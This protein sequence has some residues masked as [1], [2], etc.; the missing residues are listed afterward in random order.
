M[1]VRGQRAW[2][3]GPASGQG[4]FPCITHVHRSALSISEWGCLGGLTVS[5]V[6]VTVTPC[7]TREGSALHTKPGGIGACHDENPRGPGRPGVL[8]PAFVVFNLLLSSPQGAKKSLHIT[9][10]L[11]M[12]LEAPAG[13]VFY[14]KFLH[15][16]S[17]H[18]HPNPPYL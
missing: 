17:P 18:T 9:Q 6:G 16:T 2:G 3:T 14:P 8:R 12:G 15:P 5:I 11:P 13:A 1:Q 4:S 10:H 7:H